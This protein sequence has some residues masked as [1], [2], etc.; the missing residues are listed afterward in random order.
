MVNA[1]LFGLRSKNLGPHI[2]HQIPQTSLQ[3]APKTGRDAYG[4]HGRQGPTCMVS[5]TTGALIHSPDNSNRIVWAAAA[6]SLV[7]PSGRKTQN[8]I[9][10]NYWRHISRPT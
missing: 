4:D 2:V 5:A 10:E 3:R 7:L 8:A 6:P 9:R 1:A